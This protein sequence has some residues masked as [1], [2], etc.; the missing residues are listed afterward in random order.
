MIATPMTPKS[1]PSRG[2]RS[3]CQVELVRHD[4]QD[5]DPPMTKAMITDTS[6]MFECS[7]ACGSA[8]VGP[9]VCAEHEEPSVESTVHIPPRRARAGQDEHDGNVAHPEVAASPKS[10]TRSPCRTRARRGRRADT[11]ATL[12][13]SRS[14]GRRRRASRPR[15]FRKSS[16]L[17]SLYSHPSTLSEH[18]VDVD[19]DDEI[20]DPDGDEERPGDAV[21][22][23][24]PTFWAAG[25]PLISRPRSGQGPS[26]RRRWSSVR[27]R[28]RAPPRRPLS[29][30]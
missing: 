11:C 20:D 4:A 21:P 15:L 7:R 9:A 29:S 25:I 10:A 28:R 26:G 12:R 5:L 23:S 16:R 24:P 17:S 22:M 2:S 8:D 14:I 13:I 18:P 1:I 19:E 3:A 6:V 27:A 30:A